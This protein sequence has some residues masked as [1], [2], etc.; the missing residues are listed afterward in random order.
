MWEPMG[1]G[2]FIRR[3]DNKSKGGLLLPENYKPTHLL[4]EV[5]AIGDGAKSAFN[6]D[7]IKSDIEVGWHVL[8]RSAEGVEWPDDSWD[9][10][11]VLVISPGQVV[12]VD[13]TPAAEIATHPAGKNNN[14][15]VQFSKMRKSE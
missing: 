2:I 3:L 1:D 7:T 11:E 4:G 12:A 5:I 9:D 14:N 8:V 13:K 6:G 15:I 10:D